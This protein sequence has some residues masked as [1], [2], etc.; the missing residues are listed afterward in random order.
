ML[1][2][3]KHTIYLISLVI[4][5]NISAEEWKN[6]AIEIG[7]VSGAGKIKEEFNGIEANVF[8]RAFLGYRYNFNDNWGI[9]T[10]FNEYILSFSKPSQSQYNM[11]IG[12]EFK[13]SATE[14]LK[15]I[16]NGGLSKNFDNKGSS[17]HYDDSIGA[18]IGTGLRLEFHSG[19]NLAFTVGYED[20]K[21]YRA[22]AYGFGLGFRF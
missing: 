13:Y 1:K 22:V 12:G 9:E 7:I 6:N 5:F 2:C 10:Q 20:F 18:Y 4:S 3:L 16:I 14:R 17:P 8:S 21:F 15:L 11:K 19:F